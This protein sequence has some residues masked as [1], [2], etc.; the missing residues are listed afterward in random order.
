LSLKKNLNS[1]MNP[2]EVYVTELRWH[3]LCVDN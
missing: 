2:K 3:C 1:K